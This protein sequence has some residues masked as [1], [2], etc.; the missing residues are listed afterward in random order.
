MLKNLDSLLFIS[1]SIIP[2]AWRK[3]LVGWA[4]L[5]TD[6]STLGYPKKVEEAG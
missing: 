4:K 5:N 1:K 6:G 3:P 2:V